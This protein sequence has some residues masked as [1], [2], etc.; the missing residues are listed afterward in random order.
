M[1]QISQL[2]AETSAT[3]QAQKGKKL[4]IASQSSISFQARKACIT[5]RIVLVMLELLQNSCFTDEG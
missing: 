5:G 1:I 2:A 3:T 4:N